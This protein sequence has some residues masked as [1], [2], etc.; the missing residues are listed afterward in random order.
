MAITFRGLKGTAL[1][2]PEMDTNLASYYLSSSVSGST[3]TFFQSGSDGLVISSSHDLADSDSQTLNIVG[4]QLSISNGNTVTVPTGS[5]TTYTEGTGIDITN[6]VITN[7]S[8]DQ[9]VSLTGQ[10]STTVT[11]TYP[12]FIISSSD[13]NDNTEY[14]AGTGIDITNEVITNTSPDQTVTLIGQNITVNGAYPN[15]QLTGSENTDTNYTAGTGLTLTGTEFSLTE[16]HFSGDYNDLINTP[17]VS[18][19]L[20][21]MI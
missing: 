11:G 16:P 5:D 20:V 15:F 4:D 6:E 19:S 12:T 1:S 17:D 2:H 9:I 7:T 18:L 13:T 21:T 3:I 8:P 14:T 10:G